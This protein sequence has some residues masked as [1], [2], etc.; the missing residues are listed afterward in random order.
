MKLI[1]ASTYELNYF[2]LC[3]RFFSN[4]SLLK[5]IQCIIIWKWGNEYD[6]QKMYRMML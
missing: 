6:M 5:F 3:V 1:D 4:K 2:L